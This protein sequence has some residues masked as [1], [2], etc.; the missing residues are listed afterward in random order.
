MGDLLKRS[1]DLFVKMRWLKEIDKAVDQYNKA[2]VKARQK[3]YVLN[4]LLN[5]YKEKYGEDLSM[6]VGM[7]K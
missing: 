1:F 6:P 4:E 7:C 3:R 5:A 2:T